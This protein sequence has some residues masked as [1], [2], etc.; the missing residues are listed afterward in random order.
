[1]GSPYCPAECG[2]DA[3]QF[4]I[5]RFPRRPMLEPVRVMAFPT[6]TMY[7]G[8]PLSMP[9]YLTFGLKAVVPYELWSMDCMVW[10]A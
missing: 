6:G 1:M 2:D 8:V 3:H 4:S 5:H 7:V 10:T 9:I